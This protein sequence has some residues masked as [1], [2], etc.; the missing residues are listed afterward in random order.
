MWKIHVS[1]GSLGH[2]QLRLPSVKQ[3]TPATKSSMR[4]LPPRIS[5]GA[6]VNR[7]IPEAAATFT[8]FERHH[9]YERHHQEKGKGERNCFLRVNWEGW[10][11]L[12]PRISS[13]KQASS[14]A[15]AKSWMLG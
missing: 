11:W 15:L 2:I 5:I 4:H 9:L 7:P 12:W 14:R 10:T 13:S 1:K 6:I 8:R 3:Y